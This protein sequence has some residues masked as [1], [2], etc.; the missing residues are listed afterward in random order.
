MEYSEILLSLHV[1]NFG[2]LD[3]Y[4]AKQ[5]FWELMNGNTMLYPSDS[6]SEDY[7]HALILTLFPTSTLT[8]VSLA[9]KQNMRPRSLLLFVRGCF[10]IV[11]LFII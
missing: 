8:G 1:G 5:C 4:A 3:F 2:C 11:S 7:S 6:F 10:V 9:I